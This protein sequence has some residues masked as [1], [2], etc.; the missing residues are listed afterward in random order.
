M[1]EISHMQNWLFIND[2]DT[3]MKNVKCWQF[4]QIPSGQKFKLSRSETNHNDN[5]DKKA[6]NAWN[7]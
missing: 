1:Y 2:Q 4:F 6:G 3:G 7:G 5:L